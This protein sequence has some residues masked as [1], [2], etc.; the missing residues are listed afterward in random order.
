MNE[1][2]LTAAEVARMLDVVLRI[3]GEDI[4]RF[5]GDGVIVATPVGSTA[6]SLAA[7]GPI[8][9]PTDR[10]LIFTPLASQAMTYR[11]LILRPTRTVELAVIEARH[12]TSVTIDGGPARPLPTGSVVEIRASDHDVRVASIVDRS[13]F[14]TLRERLHWGSPLIEPGS[15]P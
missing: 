7:G 13:R 10:C 5:R 6:H 14:R 9:E 8:V 11:P 3:D 2:V 12:G 1:V 4:T 15:P